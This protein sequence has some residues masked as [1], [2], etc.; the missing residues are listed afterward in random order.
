MVT[1]TSSRAPKLPDQVPSHDG[2]CGAGAA[3]ATTGGRGGPEVG[4]PVAKAAPDA[5]VAAQIRE[6]HSFKL[7]KNP[8]NLLLNTQCLIFSL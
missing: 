4:L 2:G 6:A 5:S 7:M 3:G 8:D 1:A